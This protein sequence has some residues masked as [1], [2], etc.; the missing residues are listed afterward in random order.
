MENIL[1]QINE[2][3]EKIALRVVTLEESDIPAMGQLLNYLSDLEMAAKETDNPVFLQLTTGLKSYLEKIILYEAQDL[4]PFEQGITVLQDM[5]R[6]LSCEKPYV[7][8]ISQLLKALGI[9]DTDIET[10]GAD[11]EANPTGNAPGLVVNQ[12]DVQILS[13]FVV[14]SLEN[15]ETIEINLIDLE[16]N[17]GN[18]ETI[19]AIFRPFHT[20][21]GVSGFL[22]LKD[23]NRLSHATENLLDGA[24]QGEFQI[25][26][27]VIDIILES[28]DTLK[29]MIRGVESSL[30]EGATVI[31]SGMDIGLLIEKIKQIGQNARQENLPLGEILL[32]KG[33]LKS[34]D[35]ERSLQKQKD[36]P[37][38]RLGEILISEKITESKAVIS[39]LRDQKKGHRLLDLQVKVDTKKL[40]NLVDLTGELVIAQAMLKQN[41]QDFSARLGQRCDQNFNHL[42][43]IVSSLQKIAMSMRMVPIKSMF[44]KMFRVVRDL[45]RNSG[46]EVDLEMYGEDTEI[47]RNVVDELYEPMVHMIRNSVDHGIESPEE[48]VR[49]G[50]NRKGKVVL[51]AYHKGG[52]IIIEIEDDGKGLN[53]NGILEKAIS[54]NLIDRDAQLTESEIFDLILQPGFST[55]QQVT[56]ISGRGVGMD[57][58]K[59]SIEKLHGRLDIQSEY[60]RGTNFVIRLPLTLAIIEGMLVRVG[61]ERYVIPTMTIIES[62][63]PKK[64]DYY[65]VKGQGEMIMARGKLLPLIRLNRICGV[66]A[67]SDNPWDGLVVVIENKNDQRCL[68]LDELLGQEEIVIKSLGESLKKVK[69]L[70]GGAILGDGRV[71]LILDMAGL[72]EISENM[73]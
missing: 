64:E 26:D 17:P 8:D 49:I 18:K 33:T 21:K 24:R 30:S 6:F 1:D 58:V 68:L 25:K 45:A 46:K 72:F 52:N 35:L 42:A 12:E 28:V 51:R 4:A 63:K 19:N 60:G 66:Q 47:D 57:V 53:K 13:D 41:A 31:E 44:Q 27:E 55:A 37:G 23:I 67:D 9:S 11:D 20:V 54:K 38:K 36:I 50:K 59:R 7:S 5:Y 56:E 15:L 71:G 69:G 2:C 22:N 61:K 34:E 39:A 62:I 43:Q 48:R 3:L 40:D 10:S 14:E 29:K 70:A 32:R 65:T 16:Q 73:K